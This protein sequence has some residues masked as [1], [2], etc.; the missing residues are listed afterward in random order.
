MES[1]R[2]NVC[3]YTPS[4]FGGH[5][6][7]THAILSALSEKGQHEDVQVSLVTSRD[8][9]PEYRT[10][11]Y[12]IHDILPPLLPRSA[13][14]SPV[15]WGCSRI[16]HYHKRERTFLRWIEKHRSAC[17][18]IHFQEP[19]WFAPQHFRLLKARGVHLFYTV[20]NVYPHRYLA[21][22]FKAPHYLQLSRRRTALR[23]C[24]A[25]FV[26]TE[27]LRKEL[28]EFLG[29]GH[30]PIFVAPHGVWN[31][32]DNAHTV[33]S[34][35]ERVRRRHLLFFGVAR[36]NKGLHTLLRAM[37]RLADCT[38]TVAG[39]P[40]ESRYQEKVRAMVEQLP[41]GRVEHIDRFVEEDEMA[42]LFNQ[43]S[44]VIL[45]YISFTAQSGVLHD[46]LS[47]GLPV[48]A[49]DVGALG[50]SVR[51]WGI[52]QVV[53]PGDDVALAGA[54]REML[55]PHCY[56]QA[57]EAIDHVRTDLSWERAAETM[58]EA[59]RSITLGGSKAIAT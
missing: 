50:E 57:T 29:A 41:P 59:Y 46:A 56:L 13:F 32:A 1:N 22:K 3:M 19:M 11:L 23:L 43:S 58:I 30:P 36:R 35:E 37:E 55:T 25:L 26:H 17:E 15:T 18:A 6:R 44:L 45:P 8:L 9:V 48:V 51:Q 42:R 40:E 16:V 12:P 7:Y 38:L 31:P 21:H 28:A 20:H 2:L 14:R 39:P 47:Y 52:G 24:D 4:A 49:T 34:A 54:I 53:P 33:N 27:N 10:S 5:A